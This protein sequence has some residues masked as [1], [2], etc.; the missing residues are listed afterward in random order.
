[1]SSTTYTGIE[2]E[3]LES[4]DREWFLL[5]NGWHAPAF[6]AIMWRLSQAAWSIPWFLLIFWQLNKRFGWQRALAIAGGTGVV[7]LLCDRISVE[8]FKNVFQRYRPTHN[9]EIKALVHTVLDRNGNPYRGGLYGF[10][11]SHA[12]NFFGM[13]IYF[14]CWLRAWDRWMAAVLLGWAA[15]VSYSRIYLG[16]HYPGDIIGG[17]LLGAGLGWL[18][19]RIVRWVIFRLESTLPGQPIPEKWT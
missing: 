14:M 4:L 18:A 16:V 9:L 8:L 15:V 17:A 11:S 7:I 10:V 5:F 12:T 19:F 1:M 13:A 6:D 2:V 3:W